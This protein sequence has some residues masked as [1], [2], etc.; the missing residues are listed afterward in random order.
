[1]EDEQFKREQRRMREAVRA[2]RDGAVGSAGVTPARGA[3]DAARTPQ[4]SVIVVCWNAAEVLGRCLA[5]L[6][7]QHHPNFEIIVVD[8]GSTDR[9]AEV[10]EAARANGELELIR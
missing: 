8:D 6:F 4:V 9:T 10:A 2:Q 7:A 5:H 1:M 3:G